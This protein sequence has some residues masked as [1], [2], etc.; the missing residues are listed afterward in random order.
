MTFF[1]NY[2]IFVYWFSVSID[3]K[4]VT[5]LYYIKCLGYFQMTFF[6]WLPVNPLHV[7]QLKGEFV[8]ASHCEVKL[9]SA[10]LKAQ[11]F[12]LATCSV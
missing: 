9:G 3:D 11:N 10:P 7:H 8:M 2:L 5:L 4:N 1:L 12:K 6:S